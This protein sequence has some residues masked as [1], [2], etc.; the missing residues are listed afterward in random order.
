M[1]PSRRGVLATRDFV[2]DCLQTA[3]DQR[4]EIIT[5]LD[6]A[7]QAGGVAVSRREHRNASV[8]IRSCAKAAKAPVTVLGYVERDENGRRVKTDTP[9]EYTLQLMNEFEATEAVTRPFA[10]LVPPSASEA[11]ANLKRH[12]LNCKSFAKTLSLT[13]RSIKSMRSSGRLVGLRAIT[14][15]T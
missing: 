15:S 7:R 2:L 13:W 4:A 8:P 3:A 9:K 11:I 14:W 5:L 10:Y 6:Q 12:G 1:L